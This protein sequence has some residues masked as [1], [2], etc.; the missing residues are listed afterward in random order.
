MVANNASFNCNSAKLLVHPQASGGQP[1]AAGGR[2]RAR[3]WAGRRCARR[4]TRARRSAGSSSPRAARA[5]GWSATPG[6]GELPYALIPDVDPRS[7]DD[8]VFHQEPWCAVLSETGLPGA[9]DRVAFLEEAVTFVNEKVWGTLCAH[10]RRPP[11]DAEGPRRWPR[12]WRRPS[13]SCATAPWPST[14]GPRAVFAPGEPA[15]G[16][17]PVVDP[18]GHPE[19]PRLGAQHV[20]ARGHREG[21]APRAA[22]R[23]PALALGAGPPG[24]ASWGAG[25]WTSSWRRPG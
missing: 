14:P 10:A 15:V 18:A 22:H 16:R 6:Q 8:R 4:T 23:L 1:R 19:R 5:C 11:E 2:D 24:L 20:H 12:R 13:A 9:D 3:A 21:R 17:P 25:W 7:A